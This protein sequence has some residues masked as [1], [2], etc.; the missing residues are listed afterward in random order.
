MASEPDRNNHDLDDK[1]AWILIAVLVGLASAV[2]WAI[3]LHA[4]NIV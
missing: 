2:G 3:L 1:Q 4:W